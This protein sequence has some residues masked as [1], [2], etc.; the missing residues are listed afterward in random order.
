MNLQSNEIIDLI[1]KYEKTKKDLDEFIDK[2]CVHLE[3]QANEYDFGHCWGTDYCCKLCNKKFFMHTKSELE[4]KHDEI[5]WLE[6]KK[7]NDNRKIL[8][9]LI[10]YYKTLLSN[11]NSLA[12]FKI[13]NGCNHDIMVRDTNQTQNT[14]YVCSNCTIAVKFNV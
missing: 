1:N 8:I 7:L 12:A 9:E 10:K 3:Y 6:I 2:K 4:K 5:I 14:V 11:L 13:P